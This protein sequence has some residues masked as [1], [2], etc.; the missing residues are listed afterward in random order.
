MSHHRF[1]LRRHKKPFPRFHRDY[2]VPNFPVTCLGFPTA[3]LSSA[4]KNRTNQRLDLGPITK[5]AK[6]RTPWTLFEVA[7][8]KNLLY[9]S[10]LASTGRILGQLQQLPPR[11]GQHRLWRQLSEN[12]SNYFKHTKKRITWFR[13]FLPVLG[14]KISRR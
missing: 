4:L 9:A 12:V 7:L 2:A 8:E 11:N 6:F 1:L 13:Q 14:V 5:M 3:K 10:T